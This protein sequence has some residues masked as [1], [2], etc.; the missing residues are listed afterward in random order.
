VAIVPGI[1]VGPYEIAALIG[2][3]GMGQVYRATDTNLK[4]PVA[5]K[6]LPAALATDTE[7]LAR[8][9]R[10]AELLARLN[11]PNIAQIHGL[12]RS[13]GT[14]A[15]VMELVEGPTLADVIVRGPIQI[16]EALALAKQIA[17]AL[18]AAHEQG[19]VHRDL[20]PAN[21]KV[22][23][24]GS[25]K[26]LDFG[27]AKALESPASPDWS[28]S[29]T[30]SGVVTRAGVILGTSAY[31]SPEQARGLA[32]DKRT[33]IW[34]FG[35]VLYEMLTGHQAFPGK[36]I[37]D[38]IAAI[39]EREPNWQGLPTATP[40]SVRRL[41]S[42][43]LSKDA[44]QRLHDIAD[45]RLEIE[46]AS[47]EPAV[48]TRQQSVSKRRWVFASLFAVVIAAAA[49]MAGRWIN[50][51]TS[52]APTLWTSILPPEKPF[53]DVVPAAMLSPDGR[54]LAFQAPNA[55]GQE[56]IWVR[57]LDSG[58]ARALPGTEDSRELFWS[59]DGRSLGFFAGGR[60]KRIDLA[61]GAPQILADAPDARGGSWASDDTILFVPE[62]KTIHRIHASGGSPT[63][64]TQLN[65][66]R[67]DLIHGWPSVLPDNKHFLLWV[68]TAERQHEGVYV[69]TLDS[70]ELR[71][72][73]PL[74][75]RAQYANGHLFF[76]REGNLMAQRF[77]P[78]TQQLSGEATRVAQ[79]LGL[80]DSE[81]GNTAFSVSNTGTI[82]WWSGTPYAEVQPTWVDRSGRTIATLGEAGLYNGVVP[83]PNGKYVATERIDVLE[84]TGDILLLDLTG[85]NP[86]RLTFVPYSAGSP[87][88]SPDS[89][90]V[91]FTQWRDHLDVMPVEGGAAQQIP[92][93][94]GGNSDYPLSWSPDDRY[95]LFMRSA[96]ETRFD[97][98]ILPMSGDRTPH[99]YLQTPV[100]E[101]NGRIS[102]DGQWVAYASNESGRMEVFVQSFPVPG[103]KR[104]ISTSG[105]NSPIWR[106]DGRE[107]YF[108]TED[109]TLMAVS[110]TPRGAE[111]LDFSPPSRLFQAEYITG[112]GRPPWAPSVDGQRF[113]VLVP[114]E[115]DQPQGINL[116]HNWR[117]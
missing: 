38:A 65:T 102:P 18:E 70:G 99:P 44:R 43:C 62:G 64:V 82:A 42:R 24:D 47:S 46:S 25:V 107:V 73:L 2:E 40:T 32:I 115:R 92:L 34:A 84:L 69:A 61:G 19:I 50:S 114:V 85:G 11:H 104:R 60:L 88:W 77:D 100:G 21:V 35:C 59:P 109:H 41:L 105:G 112:G 12:E 96:P 3:G 54:A 26:V 108:V 68:L 39:L 66:E 75:T 30:M 74:R 56:V 89:K 16:D 45:A 9:Q 28:Q 53:G 57:P 55:A 113:L 81:L 90:R 58:V 110:V 13:D 79:G 31:M 72:L 48:E 14:T 117:P 15:L 49:F 94:G 103:N 22:K 37:S 116:L 8:F 71:P 95:L 17:A 1:R 87:V 63:E 80:Y 52:E 67:R 6:V 5:I 93:P 91:L 98:W 83:S 10:E 20:K 36:T 7:R 23:A 78:D 111:S 86:S 27:L 101:F 76:G 106:Q 29:P 33:D 97:L 51:R 4:R